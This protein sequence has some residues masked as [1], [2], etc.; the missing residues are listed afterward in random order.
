MADDICHGCQM[1]EYSDYDDPDWGRKYIHMKW[2]E[3]NHTEDK[4]VKLMAVSA[5]ECQII[6]EKLGV[7][8]VV[9]ATD[10][11]LQHGE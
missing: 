9:L 7:Q 3:E 5:D 8:A 1:S 11:K 2:K 4:T 6:D 10:E